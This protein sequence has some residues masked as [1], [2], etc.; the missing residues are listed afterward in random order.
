MLN[1][2]NFLKTVLG[3]KDVEEEEEE[4]DEDDEN[5]DEP[6]HSPI[7]KNTHSDTKQSVSNSLD[8]SNI[9]KALATLLQHQVNAELRSQS[10]MEKLG[11]AVTTSIQPPYDSESRG[12]SKS[13]LPN[14]EIPKFSGNYVDWPPFRDMFINIVHLDR[15]LSDV[16]RMHYLVTNVDG[17]AKK[18][19]KTLKITN[20][21]C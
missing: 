1:S 14:I 15:N 8:L 13:K 20:A 7:R 2:E 6:S 11:E 19:I 4:V 10:V 5:G 3:R 12:S 16:Q 9:E 17:N 21:N 18:M